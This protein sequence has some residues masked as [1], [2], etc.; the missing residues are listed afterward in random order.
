MQLKQKGVTERAELLKNKLID[1]RRQLHRFPEL[2]F[3]EER[4]SAY[5]LN[6]LKMLG[7]FDIQTGI[8][9]HGIVASIGSGS[10]PVIG[11][12]ADMDALPIE[13]KT[14]L[15]FASEHAGIMHACGH[16]AH[17]A[18][19]LG[20][21]QLLAEDYK[22]GRLKGRIK[23]LF[24]PAEEDT[25]EHG[26]TG[27]PYFLKEGVIDDMD[28]AL[29]IHVCP[30]RKT[31]EIQLNAGPS[32]AS[33][34]NFSLTVYGTGG[35]G[36]YPHQGVD[37]VWI[38]SLI[39]QGVYSLTGRKINPM[40]PGVISIGQINGGSTFNVIPDQIRINGTIRA[41]RQEER[42]LLLQELERIARISETLGGS[43]K[44]QVEK[45]EPALC[46]HEKAI[47]SFRQTAAKLYPKMHI[48]N[49][50]Y[51]MGGEDFSY[52]LERVPGAMLFL[53]CGWKNQPEYQLHTSEFQLDEA[54]LP[55]GVSLLAGC[56]QSLME[57]PK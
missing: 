20:T 12:R 9:G 50:P 3:Q 41:Y 42:N 2:S 22:A 31:G 36:G 54:A 17:T 37:P 5:V 52:I 56:I 32:M 16:D 24:Q 44:L 39:L 7:G 15:E 4:T 14:N 38:T 55:I 48:F 23:F 28:M 51:G 47:E 8:A 19:L 27:A 35:H 21:A 10:G 1:W 53:G 18:M 40:E 33:I 30:W 13:E 6:E 11:I 34:D 57:D 46:N 43:Y 25:D 45:G 26:Q 29:A 49:E